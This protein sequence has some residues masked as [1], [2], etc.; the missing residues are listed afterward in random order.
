MNKLL[1]EIVN[2]AAQL[3]ANRVN[4]DQSAYDVLDCLNEILGTELTINN[5]YGRVAL[6]AYWVAE[7]KALS[8]SYAVAYE[9]G[10]KAGNQTAQ[11]MGV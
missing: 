11:S 4:I 7:E 5:I 9:A 3:G 8:N 6:N 10:I 1:F 2:E